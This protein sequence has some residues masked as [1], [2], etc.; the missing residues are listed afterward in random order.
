MEEDHKMLEYQETMKVDI[1]NI[2]KKKMDGDQY[3]KLFMLH[4]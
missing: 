1:E 4:F 3:M 2:A